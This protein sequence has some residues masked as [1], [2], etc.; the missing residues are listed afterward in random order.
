M[1]DRYAE[2]YDAL[3]GHKDYEAECDFLE[4]VFRRHGSGRV[5]RVLDLGC[6]TGGHALPLAGRGYRVVG[7]DRSE[8]MVAQA[9]SKAEAMAR[10]GMPG[11]AAFHVSDIR[12]LDLGGERSFDAVI[13][14]FAVFSYLRSNEEVSASFQT[15]RRFLK[16][17]GLF[18]FDAWFGPAVLAERPTDRCRIIERDGERILR[19][20]RADLD[21]LSH[22][23]QIDYS[24]LR[25]KEG[26][27]LDQVEETHWQRFFFP[28]EIRHYLNDGGFS[29]LKLCPFMEP[30]REPTEKD[31]YFAAISQAV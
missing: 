3:Y 14:M 5:E 15:A 17:G 25:L 29:L 26:R 20:A 31:W 21:V 4:G 23:V 18:V 22:A 19:F 8:A 30:E 12:A 27:I 28:Q 6:G 24:L 9:R 2:Y 7:V 11:A 13:A 1:F 10:N 16:P